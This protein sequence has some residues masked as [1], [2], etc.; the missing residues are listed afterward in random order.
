MTRRARTE[1]AFNKWAGDLL[2]DPSTI[3]CAVKAVDSTGVVLVDGGGNPIQSVVSLADLKVQALDFIYL[4]RKKVDAT[5]YSEI[6]SRVRYQFANTFALPDDTIVQIAFSDSGGAASDRSFDEILP[7]A[8]A[9]REM[10]GK[11]RPLQAKDFASASKTAAASA[12]NPGNLDIAELKTRVAGIRTEFDGLFT[13]LD[14]TTAAADALKT[15]AAVNTLREKLLAIADAGVP[16]AFPLSST[17]FGDTERES[18]LAQSKSLHDRYETVKAAYDQSLVAVNAPGTK[19]AQQ[20]TQLTAMARAFLGQ[21]FVLLPHFTLD[22]P[23]DVILADLNRD[24][25]LN[26]ARTTLNMSLP[27]EEWIDGVSLVRPNMHTF[28]TILMLSDAFNQQSPACRPMQLP[29]RDQDTWLAIEFA[30]GTTIVH[31]TIALLQCLPQGFNPAGTLTGLLIDE[32][33][34]TLPQKEEVSGILVQLR[35]AEQRSAVCDPA[36][37]HPAGDRQMEL[38][39]PGIYRSRH[40]CARQA[41]R[42]RARHDR[43]HGRV[44]HV[45][46]RY[47]L[48]VQHQP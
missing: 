46:A 44:Q 9:V 38:G 1:T 11:A 13:S 15:Q 30:E 29:Y 5:G 27:L 41:A 25:L 48:R 32:W 2:G 7:F 36:R 12:D 22:D 37:R 24:Q 47:H 45:A 8:N 42:R 31:D 19:P 39:Q 17:G 26:Y 3:K 21:D 23:A 14:T 4:I 6:E 34:E 28:A 20:F 33:T 16:H 40:V 18:L 43:H 35:S 10:A